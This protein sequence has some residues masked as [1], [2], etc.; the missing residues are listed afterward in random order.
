MHDANN[1]WLSSLTSSHSPGKKPLLINQ[2]LERETGR[3]SFLDF[4][5]QMILRFIICSMKQHMQSKGWGR[6]CGAHVWVPLALPLLSCVWPPA[7]LAFSCCSRFQC[8]DS[9]THSC[10]YA[11]IGDLVR[12]RERVTTSSQHS[13][14]LVSSVQSFGRLFASF[15]SGNIN[16]CSFLVGCHFPDHSTSSLSGQ[17]L[18]QR[19]CIPL[20][21][22]GMA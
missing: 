13:C 19:V 2:R 8:E 18:R 4:F 1:G 14:G 12:H 9:P 17:T 16:L 3:S 6:G 7:K 5:I 15:W 10:Y 20:Q 11:G 22:S 21:E